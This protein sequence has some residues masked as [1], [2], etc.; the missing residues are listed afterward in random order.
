MKT[1]EPDGPVTLFAE[2]LIG[3]GRALAHHD[4][5]TWMVEGAL[6][7]ETVMALETRRR[8]GITEARTVDV[9]ADRHP[10]RLSDPCPHGGICGG[11]DWPHVDPIGGARLKAAAAAEAA[12]SA[13]DLSSLVAG[14]HIHTSGPGYRLRARLHWDPATREIG[15]YETRSQRVSPIT[16]CR[17]LSPTLMAALPVLRQAVAGRCPEPVDLEWIEGSDPAQAVAALRP[18]KGGPSWVPPSWVPVASEVDGVVS[19]FHIVSRTGDLVPNWG[20]Q[21]VTYDLPLRLTVPMG[22]F[23]QGNR[24]LLRPLFD[25]V[26]DLVGG[27]TE[28]VFDLHAGVGFLAAAASSSGGHPLTLVE[29][30][31]GAAKAAKRNLP[32]AAVAVGRT[33]EEWIEGKPDLRGCCVITDPPRTGM[34]KRLRRGLAAWMPRRILMLG[35]DPA[36]WARD[37]RFLCEQGYRPTDL[38]LFDLFPSTHHVE[39][40]ALLERI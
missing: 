17:I 34:S 14:A 9:V 4:G 6:P 40:L 20:E 12:R 26:A 22:A 16:G 13:P 23:F 39:I 2:K 28:P 18:A 29:P 3:G 37:A 15:F 7:D 38:E 32:Q 8:A 21:E 27:G 5:R 30:N 33:A 19:G 25:R 10:A 24:H 35:C 11:C 1:D 31:R 36:T